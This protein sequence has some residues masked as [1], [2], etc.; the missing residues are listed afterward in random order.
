MRKLSVAALCQFILFCFCALAFGQG[1]VGMKSVVLIIPQDQFQDIEFNGVREALN[2]AGFKVQVASESLGESHGM[3]G[4]V[5]RPDMTL[6]DIN[7]RNFDAVVFVGGMGSMQYW[8]N[9]VA[10]DLAKKAFDNNRVVA[11]ICLA[12][13]TLAN[14]GILKGRRA[15]VSFSAQ[16]KLESQGANYTGR[17][18]EVDGNIITGSGP[19]STVDFA[20]EII[21][22]LNR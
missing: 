9:A 15:T 16:G 17:L 21:K 3:L 13:V 12:P 22:A 8:N 18:V 19:D 10:K 7:V 2:K 5:A 20:R 6:D 14:A 4:G 1:E 11:A